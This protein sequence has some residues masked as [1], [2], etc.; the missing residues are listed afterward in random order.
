MERK[1]PILYKSKINNQIAYQK[2]SQK[3]ERVPEEY[4]VLTDEVSRQNGECQLFLVLF[5]NNN[6]K[7]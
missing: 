2:P 5:N 3:V 1:G 7:V 4:V 6:N